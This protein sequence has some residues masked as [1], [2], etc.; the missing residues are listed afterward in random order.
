MRLTAERRAHIAAAYA[1]G[2]LRGPAGAWVERQRT[3]DAALCAAVTAWQERLARWV[4]LLAP[5]EPH[6]EVW[7]ALERRIVS[8]EPDIAARPFA[9]P[10]PAP[11]EPMA[12]TLWRSL[13]FWRGASG[14]LFATAFALTIGLALLLRPV[15]GP[16]H[17]AVLADAQ[18]RPVWILD[19]RLP[20]GH[21]AVRALPLAAPPP[22]HA[23]ELWMLPASGAPV[24]L[25]LCPREGT[26]G[27]DL[28]PGLGTRLLTAAGLA[29]S[30]EPAGGSPT[31]QPTGPVVFQ[32]VL[33]RT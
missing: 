15:P 20:A 30:L 12:T 31:G 3:R 6:D 27:I 21:L 5:V 11:I 16:T 4:E 19:A 10:S 8:P 23:Y 26:V 33:V 14:A 7:Q 9:P 24:S 1:V 32:A 13:G 2:T 28:A 29:V 22:D 17:T 18:G 25:G